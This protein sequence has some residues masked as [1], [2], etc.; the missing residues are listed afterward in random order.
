MQFKAQETIESMPEI[1]YMKQPLK[2]YLNTRR[3]ELWQ[4]I[5]MELSQMQLIEK[6]DACRVKSV[7]T[8]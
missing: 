8:H 7:Q 5:Q 6:S 2:F 4:N 3:K 1:Q